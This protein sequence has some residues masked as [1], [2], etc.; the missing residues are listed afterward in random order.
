M[1]AEEKRDFA[2][3][4]NLRKN[5]TNFNFSARI[6]AGRQLTFDTQNWFF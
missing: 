2:E 1:N 4:Q 5:K 6:Y 3:K